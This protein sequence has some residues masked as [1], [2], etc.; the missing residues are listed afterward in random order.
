MPPDTIRFR[1]PWNYSE[2]LAFYCPKDHP[3]SIE[4]AFLEV[5]N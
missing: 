2:R 3:L 1:S 5:P 4:D